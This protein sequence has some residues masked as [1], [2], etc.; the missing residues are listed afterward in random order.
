MLNSMT[1]KKVTNLY[2]EKKCISL[3]NCMAFTSIRIQL[4]HASV[5]YVMYVRMYSSKVNISNC[6]N[7]YNVVHPTT[8]RDSWLPE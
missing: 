3:H 8:R 6:R 5:H 2:L 1:D 4:L 7:L